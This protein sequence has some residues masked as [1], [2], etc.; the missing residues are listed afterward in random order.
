MATRRW[1]DIKRSK[2]TPETIASIESEAKGEVVAMDLGALAGKR[3][4]KTAPS[5]RATE[6]SAASLRE[7]PEMDVEQAVRR[8]P[9]LPDPER[10][11]G[12]TPRP[13]LTEARR[14]PR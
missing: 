2:L 10:G 14:R 9:F 6:P 5:G 3:P 7:M 11:T 4:T 12:A 8:N 1:N 13:P